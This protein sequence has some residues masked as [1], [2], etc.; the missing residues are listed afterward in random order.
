M[1]RPGPALFLWGEKEMCIRDRNGALQA[2]DILSTAK[3]EQDL[4]VLCCLKHAI[5]QQSTCLL[6]TSWRPSVSNISAAGGVSFMGK[7]RP[8]T[9]VTACASTPTGVCGG[10]LEAWPPWLCRENSAS[11]WPFSPMP[12]SAQGLS[13]PG[14]TCSTTAPPSS[15]TSAGRM[16]RASSTSTICG[17]PSRCV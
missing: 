16:C 15:T 10:G 8:S 9:A 14:N 17:A 3:S 5:K 11:S 2:I 7:G 13:T 12:M 6:Y 4:R 1:R